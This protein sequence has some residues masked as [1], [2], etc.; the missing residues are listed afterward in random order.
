MSTNAPQSG[1]QWQG[2]RGWVLLVKSLLFAAMTLAGGWYC[3]HLLF[4][5]HPVA[6]ASPSNGTVNGVAAD[7]LSPRTPAT[8]A[9]ASPVPQVAPSAIGGTA[10]P[11]TTPNQGAAD[12]PPAAPAPP[13]NPAT[14]SPT[15]L[16]AQKR[17]QEAQDALNAPIVAQKPGLAGGSAQAPAQVA[18]RPDQ[19]GAEV[20]P[21]AGPFLAP[22]TEIDVTLY[23][24]IDSTI[25]GM[26]SGFVG[27]DVLDS[28]LR[29]VLIPS[30]S[31][32]I[33]QMATTGMQTG[34]SRI[35]VLWQ[36]ILLPNGYSI[37][38]DMPGIDLTGTTGF[39]A[40]VDSHMRKAITSA[41]AFSV[42]A[43]G[44]QILQPTSA[45]AG[46][47]CQQSVGGAVG[48]AVGAQ[49]ASLGSAA[50]NKALNSTPTA[51]V[52][53]GAQVGVMVTAFLPLRPWK[54][55]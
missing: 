46:Y 37:S 26:I 5:P 42:L 49:I 35:G 19:R 31:K 50:Y 3:F 45:C 54:P 11:T 15:Q 40:T 43:A 2:V 10:V 21:P 41:I 36:T 24:S 29:Y 14:P 20:A 30:R 17:A 28:T 32:I 13:P 55:E 6:A 8:Y 22:G 7:D 16:A 51:H 53:E 12:P 47:G 27:R 34:Q 48:Q 52:V 25:P 38:L 9:S 23:T 44:A 18:Q 1:V 39:G 33:G 4:A